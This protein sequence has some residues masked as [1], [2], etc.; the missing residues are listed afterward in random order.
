MPRVDPRA[1]ETVFVPR[2]GEKGDRIL[3]GDRVRQGPHHPAIFLGTQ[4]AD[5]L[6]QSRDVDLEREEHDDPGEQDETKHMIV[7][8]E[9]DNGTRDEKR[10]IL[11][12]LKNAIVIK[13]KMLK[14]A[15]K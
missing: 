2:P 10:E 9:Y 5:G 6:A 12:Y 15:C 1:E 8:K 14:I 13:N 7:Q 11:E 3:I 4:D